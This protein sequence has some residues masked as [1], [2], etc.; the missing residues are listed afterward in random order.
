MC[1]IIILMHSK[2]NI[3]LNNN[4]TATNLSSF[5]LVSL[6]ILLL[7]NR[8]ILITNSAILYLTIILWPAQNR[9]V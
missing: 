2:I 1:K 5:K 6:L 9:L 4:Q 7:S 8:L 3:I